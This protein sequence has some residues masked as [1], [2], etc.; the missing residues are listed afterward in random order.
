MRKPVSETD[1]A[2][3]GSGE[4]GPGAEA[5]EQRLERPAERTAETPRPQVDEP[6][7]GAQDTARTS[8]WFAPRKPPQGQQPPQA[9][10]EPSAPRPQAPG[11][12]P[13]GQGPGMPYFSDAPDA[14]D[15]FEGPPQQPSGPTTGP[16]YGT[17]P[18]PPVD[19]PYPTDDT[20]V[21]T[22]RSAGARPGPPPQVSGD[23]LTS[24]LPVVPPEH[25]DPFAST[26]SS[27]FPMS[28]PAQVAP[29]RG[30]AYD[31]YP[32][33]LDEPAPAAPTPPRRPSRARPRPRGR[34]S[35]RRRAAPS[36]CSSARA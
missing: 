10:P 35:R 28:G 25:R 30:G 23:T 6:G 24:G 1:K 17:S 32:P 2:A 26:G 21:L 19:D 14:R 15:G 31:P 29:E 8:D 18:V 11:R 27:P 7:P 13:Q 20:A 22:P 33:V 16:A 5:Q 12:A 3:N 36:R 4:D 34:R 9:A